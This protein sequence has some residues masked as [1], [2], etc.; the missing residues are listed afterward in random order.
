MKQLV[1]LITV[2]GPPEDKK[3]SYKFKSTQ[4]LGFH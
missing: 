2:V 4:I 1:D 3:R